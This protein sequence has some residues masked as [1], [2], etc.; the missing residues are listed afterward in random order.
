MSATESSDWKQISV[1]LPARYWVAV[2][3]LVDAGVREISAPQLEALKKRGAKLEEVSDPLKAVVSGPIFARAAIVKALHEG[4]I[5][6]TE[7]NFQHGTD[8]LVALIKR[9]QNERGD[10]K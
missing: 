6:T 7:A 4:G 2:L 1:S 8:A 3:A 10:A 5:M 9:F